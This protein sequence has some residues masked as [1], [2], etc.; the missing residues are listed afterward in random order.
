MQAGWL[1]LAAYACSGL[2]GLIYEVS[3]TRLLTLYMGHTTAATSTVVAAFMGGLAAGAAL[4]GRFAS[5]LTF[6]QVLLSYAALESVVVLMAIVIPFELTALRPLLA[7]SYRDGASGALFPM[8]RAV[9][10]F[11]I[12]LPPTIALGATFPVA[13]RWFVSNPLH[14]GRGGGGLYAANTAG[15]ALGALGAGFILMPALGLTGTVLVG[16]AASGL[17]IVVVLA[18][19]RNE[20]RPADTRQQ[21]RVQSV[22]AEGKRAKRGAWRASAADSASA[23]RPGSLWLPATV[24]A[25]TGFATFIFEIAWTRLF[26]MIIGPSTYAFAATLTALIGGV[27]AGSVVGSAVAGRTR[28]PAFMLAL[29][30]AGAAIAASWACSFAGGPLPRL[31]AKELAGSP[32]MFDRVLLLQS[33]LA[34][35]LIVPTAAA[36]G[37]AFPLALELA[38]GRDLPVARRLGAVYAVN[39]LASVAGALV[40]GFV[41]LPFIGLQH[42]LQLASAVLIVGAVTV[43]VWGSLSRA[44][45]VAAFAAAI[46]AIGILVWSPPWDRE[47]LASGIYKY[48]QY[49]GGDSDLE[50]ALTAGTLLYYREGAAATVSVKRLTG[51][52]SLAIDGKIDASTSGDMLT[53]KLLAHLP[54]LLHPD[55]HEVCIIGLGSGVTLASSLVHPIASVDVVEISPEV[56]EASRLF[57]HENRNALSD[58]RAHLVLGDGR[59]HLLFSSHTYDVIISEPSNPWMAGIAALFTREFF[60]ALRG[61]LAPGGIVCQWAHTYDI[62]DR[63]LRSVVATFASVFP[64]GTMWLVGDGDL[65]LVGSADPL[66]SRLANIARGWERPAVVADLSSVSVQDPF[67][68]WSLF[69]GGPAQLERYSTGAPLQTDDRMALEF[70]GPRALYGDAASDNAVRLIEL[71]DG[72]Q[73]PPAIARAFAAAS[74]AEWRNRGAMMLKA[75]VYAVAYHDFATAVKLDPTDS[76][77]LDG[78]ARAAVVTRKPADAIE[79]LRTARAAEPQTPAVLIAISR[80]LAASGSFDQAIAS[81]REALAVKPVDPAALEQL[82]SLYADAGDAAQLDEVVDL[83]QGLFPD[84]PGSRYYAAASQFLHGHLPEALR[85]AEQTIALDPQRAAAHNLLGA[86]QASHGETQAAHEAFEAAL[87][88]DPRDSAT[89]TNLGLLDLASHNQADALGFFAEALSLDPDSTTA[90]DGLAHA[91][92][93]LTPR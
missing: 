80:I 48:T 91:R 81:A 78:L 8:V 72:Q 90:R 20:R 93:G 25:L 59:S 60:T 5:R 44:T 18:L 36:L 76:A 88:L 34:A 70:S 53:Q 42:T 58:P 68:L 63:D 9:S 16:V 26:S 37:V 31:V 51:A 45:R 12:L 17:A 52:L 1:F 83:L 65:L 30:L 6:R 73:R 71:L 15:A 77:A 3:W 84:R 21:E 46:A 57:A 4:G 39:S 7:W 11:A 24:V 28:R 43:L 54:L 2:A 22:A 69:V 85:L 89:Y 19:A 86:I 29:A 61:R 49:V 55:P 47:L 62:S 35:A 14:P 23:S 82:A 79:V 56:V 33:I 38:G 50:T 41:A 67:G 87:L 40:S 66:D 74:A 10:C 27:A 75:D 64:N 92:A 13:V 32:R